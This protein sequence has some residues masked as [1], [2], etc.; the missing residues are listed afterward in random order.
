M[1]CADVQRN[2]PDIMDGSGDPELQAH[3]KSCA[4][5]SELVSDLGL[6]ANAAR[7]LSNVEEPPARVW[8]NIANQLRAEGIIREPQQVPARVAPVPRRWNA[9]WLAPIAAAIIAAGAYEI[10]RQAPQQ[11]AQQPAQTIPATQQSSTAV[12]TSAGTP[13]SDATQQGALQ[14]RNRS[15]VHSDSG[16]GSQSQPGDIS[17]PPAEQDQQFLSEVSEGAPAMRTTYEKQLQA[18]NE[19]ILETQ[20]YIKTHPGDVDARQHLMETYQQKAMLY[21]MALDRVQ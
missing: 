14:A 13:R 21:Q 2:Q 8:V 10:G 12:A 6:I 3:L 11:V 9:W 5:C 16:A 17:P 18:V 19:E 15:S 20:E 1:N 4:S 7:Q